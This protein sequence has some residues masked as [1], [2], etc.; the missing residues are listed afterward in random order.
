MK[1]NLHIFLRLKRNANDFAITIPVVKSK[2][3]PHPCFAG[4]I[5]HDKLF[6]RK[7][8]EMQTHQTDASLFLK[9]QIR[10]I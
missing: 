4:G 5:F 1:L 10:K 3:L 2:A 9:L 6:N 8:D 7:L